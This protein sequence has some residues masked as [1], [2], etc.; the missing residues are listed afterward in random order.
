MTSQQRKRGWAD[1]LASSSRDILTRW[2]GNLTKRGKTDPHKMQLDTDRTF[3]AIY[4]NDGA[5]FTE[6]LLEVTKHTIF[7]SRT[8]VWANNLR[9]LAV[10][11][12][13]ST[14]KAAPLSGALDCQCK[15]WGSF[16]DQLYSHLALTDYG[17]VKDCVHYVAVS[18]CWRRSGDPADNDRPYDIRSSQ[19]LRAGRAP[20]RVLDRAIRFAASRNVK[21]IWID[22]ECI[23]QDNR[24]DK[25]LGVQSMDLVYLRSRFPLGLLTCTFDEQDLVDYLAQAIARRN[26]EGLEKGM[27]LRFDELLAGQEPFS[28]EELVGLNQALGTIAQDR[29]LKRAWILQE[30]ILSG[31]SMTLLI[32][33]SPVLDRRSFGDIPGELQ[34]RVTDAIGLRNSIIQVYEESRAHIEE[35]VAGGASF[36][37]QIIKSAD[38]VTSQLTQ[39][40][41]LYSGECHARNA[42]EPANFLEFYA[43]SRIPDRLAIIGNLCDHPIRINTSAVERRRISFSTCLFA[44]AIINGDISFLQFW[45]EVTQGI[46][47]PA[48]PWLRRDLKG[49][50]LLNGGSWD[51]FSWAPSP[52]AGITSLEQY[53][54]SDDPSVKFRAFANPPLRLA[55]VELRK[56]GLCVL[57]WVWDLNHEID[58]NDILEELQ[59]SW[60]AFAEERKSLSDWKDAIRCVFRVLQMLASQSLWP[61]AEL[62]W[63]RAV[64]FYAERFWE[65]ARLRENQSS[66]QVYHAAPSL[67][68]LYDPETCR[69]DNKNLRYPISNTDFL[70]ILTQSIKG[71]N[72]SWAWIIPEIMIRGSLQYGLLRGT[73]D[74]AAS[75]CLFEGVTVRNVI[76]P[77]MRCLA[78]EKMGLLF[79]MFRRRPSSWLVAPTK[80]KDRGIAVWRGQGMVRGMWRLGDMIPAMEIIA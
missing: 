27:G 78:P 50:R 32:S 35:N 54:F 17:Q 46:E 24:E 11:S 30:T 68:D 40:W 41:R 61:V 58:M 69:F 56:S 26:R 12:H 49:P 60:D 63:R 7:Q 80:R 51:T 2:R 28:A 5:R 53:K 38:G 64:D 9:F 31:N 75:C 22:Q 57:G 37:D 15:Y 34:I 71:V 74:P 39:N 79:P 13:S 70:H 59:E 65:R 16:S 62:L 23:E 42:I 77:C 72:S 44:M 52:A 4:D 36:L 45:Q 48:T 33:C 8:R 6:D 18:Y 29:W 14:P 73:E 3:G 76:T 47:L 19:G 10:P 21:F 1:E 20:R 55:E 25:E 66:D 43:N 67:Q